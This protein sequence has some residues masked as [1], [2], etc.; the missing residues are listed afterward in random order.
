M[1]D[2]AT[3]HVNILLNLYKQRN[4]HERLASLLRQLYRE[5]VIALGKF[6][7]RTISYAEQLI[8]VLTILDQHNEIG[9]LCEELFA[10]VGGS[11]DIWDHR[12]L[13]VLFRLIDWYVSQERHIKAEEQLR[14]S[15]QILYDLPSFP[16]KFIKIDYSLPDGIDGC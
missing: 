6:D 5:C 11:L 15:W 13:I 8:D 1:D 16:C 14:S 12:R 2:R 4:K 9:N 7:T 3:V 10:G